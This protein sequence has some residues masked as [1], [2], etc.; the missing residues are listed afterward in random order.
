MRLLSFFS[1][2]FGSKRTWSGTPEMFLAMVMFMQKKNNPEYA[3]HEVL[4]WGEVLQKVIKVSL[5][6]Y[7]DFSDLLERGTPDFSVVEKLEEKVTE[8][9]QRVE[10]KKAIYGENADL[11]DDDIMKSDSE[12]AVFAR[13]F[14][15]DLSEHIQ[16][17]EDEQRKLD[18]I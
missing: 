11:G 6:P 17:P 10:L 2:L 9:H 15:K 7:K 4:Q 12:G 3:K 14:V 5:S 1:K 18:D 8:I 13:K 16:F